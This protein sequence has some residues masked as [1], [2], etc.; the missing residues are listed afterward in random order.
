MQ[1]YII[2]HGQ[3]VWNAEGRLQGRTDTELNENG[4]AAAINYGKTLTDIKFDKVFSS[5]LKRARETAELILEAK[6]EKS[7]TKKTALE[8][9]I[10][11]DPRLAEISFG[12]E[13]GSDYRDWLREGNPLGYFFTEPGKYKAPEGGEEIEEVIARTEE[14]IKEKIEPLYGTDEKIMI[15]A[16]GALNKGIM[17]YLEGNTKENFWGSGLQKNCEA[18]IFEFD[19]KIW[20]KTVT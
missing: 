4:R 2:R 9:E 1:L 7:A 14:F 16:H 11:T 10:V 13:E 5:P 19:G 8:P 17:C 12:V 6:K 20:K 3:T 18:D 15:V